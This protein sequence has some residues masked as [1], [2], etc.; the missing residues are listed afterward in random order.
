MRMTWDHLE[1]HLDYCT[2]DVP[3]N[4][5][6]KVLHEL[7]VGDRNFEKRTVKDYAKQLVMLASLLEENKKKT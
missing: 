3:P 1:S 7:G 6:E 4:V 2:F 5:S